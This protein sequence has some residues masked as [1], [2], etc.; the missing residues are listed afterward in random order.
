MEGPDED[1]N[2]RQQQLDRIGGLIE[3]HCCSAQTAHLWR[4]THS[5]PL[6]RFVLSY[7]VQERPEMRKL[8]ERVYEL[9]GKLVTTSRVVE[10]KRS[11]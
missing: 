6:L 1:Q 10:T 4:R 5:L 11:D 3:S 7:E 9:E 2:W 8:L